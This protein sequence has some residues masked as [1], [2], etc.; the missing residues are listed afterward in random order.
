MSYCENM[1]S[2]SI[3]ISPL[4][5]SQITHKYAHMDTFLITD[6]KDL[7]VLKAFDVYNKTISEL[8]VEDDYVKRYVIK[9][10]SQVRKTT[11]TKG[12]ISFLNLV[13]SQNENK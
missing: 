11:F 13:N 5:V 9:L 1:K 10:I 2:N 3:E 7:L 4:R 8:I 12:M 6:N